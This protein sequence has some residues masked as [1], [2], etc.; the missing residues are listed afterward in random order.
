MSS[1][2]IR[3]YE[4]DGHDLAALVQRAWKQSF[5]G[6]KWFPLWDQ[7][8][9]S[10]RVLDPHFR[11]RELCLGAY[12]GASLVGCIMAEATEFQWG[13]QQL[14]GSYSSWLSVDQESKSRG[15]ALRLV[16]ELRV[17]HR[18]LGLRLS[19]GCTRT[20]PQSPTRKFWDSLARRRP[21]E[22]RFW[23][24]IR[25]WAR[26]LNP[27][28]VAAAGLTTWER[29]APQLL[30][31]IP[32]W[33]GPS[34]LPRSIRPFRREDTAVCLRMLERQ[35][36][37]A[38]L[39][40]IWNVQRLSHQFANGNYPRT[41]ISQSETTPQGFLNYYCLTW[42]GKRDIRVGMIDLFAGENGW[43]PQRSL[44]K[45]AEGQ[46]RDEKID[47]ILM[48]SS[49]ASPA[50]VLLSRG[51]VPIDAEVERFGLFIDPQL[52]CPPP[53]SFHILFT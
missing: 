18:Q 41:L 1:A 32:R 34:R 8:Y 30:R 50:R 40:M 43:W 14:H 28:R 16:D 27:A 25:L 31:L 17:R 15:V 26:V 39:R 4:G 10:W 13:D 11:S 52:S 48:M 3:T 35:C 38:N 12:E 47:L 19:V 49:Q 29:W 22:F 42:S 33:A 2:E 44:L 21:E 7:D 53:R 36:E 37:P 51:F 24:P 45:A 23:G 5:Q 46:M 9:F 20:D 6:Q